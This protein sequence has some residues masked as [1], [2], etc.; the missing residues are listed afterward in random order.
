MSVLISSISA[1][2]YSENKIIR[3]NTSRGVI[4]FWSNVSKDYYS[5]LLTVKV[6]VILL[7]DMH[8]LKIKTCPLF[9]E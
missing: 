9:K 5:H 8:F 4:V 7:H 2:I 6:M 1:S 3:D